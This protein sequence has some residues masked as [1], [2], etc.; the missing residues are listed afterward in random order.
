MR[1]ATWTLLL[2]LGC[3]TGPVDGDPTPDDDDSA[4]ADD[5]DSSWVNDDDDSS[6]VDDDDSA[7]LPLPGFGD[8]DGACGVIEP[9][10][11]DSTSPWHFDNELDFG[12]AA[13]DFDLLS[14]GGQEI[15][16]DGN[17]GGDSIYS[18]IFAFEVLHRCELAVLLKTETEIAYD[19]DGGKKTDLLVEIDGDRVGVSVTRALGWPPE[20][21]W[22]LEQA[23]DLLRDKLADIPLSTANVSAEDAWDKQ[24]LHVLAYSPEHAALI[25]Q[26]WEGL[27]PA[28]RGDTIVLST[29][30][31]GQDGFLY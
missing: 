14:E 18:E 17:L 10:Q 30:T 31:E 25:E 24:I 22:T 11:L 8:I 23:D 12:D 13:Y 28:L 15:W 9:K 27:E 6:L 5:D 7:P 20:E 2:L 16:N 19:D 4:P 21:P 3:P 26:A 1:S 29:A